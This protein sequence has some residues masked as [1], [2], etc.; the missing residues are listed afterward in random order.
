MIT[1]NGFQPLASIITERFDNT[2]KINLAIISGKIVNKCVKKR[3]HKI[4]QTNHRPVFK[5]TIKVK[6]TSKKDRV[7]LKTY[8]H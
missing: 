2:Q 8:I 3:Q 7:E 5:M 4:K 1:H 6:D